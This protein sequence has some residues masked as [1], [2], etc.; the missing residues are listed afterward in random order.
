MAVTITTTPVVAVA[1][2]AANHFGMGEV[3]DLHAA[4]VPAP[5][6]T[7]AWRWDVTG[8]RDLGHF[9]F[10]GNHARAIFFAP[11]TMSVRV[12]NALDDTQATIDLQIEAPTQWS[13]GPIQNRYHRHN[14]A[15]AA[16]RAAVQIANPNHVS[17]DNLEMR[18]GNA[19]P[20]CTGRYV[21]DH[22]NL[23]A[24]HGATFG[25]HATWLNIGQMRAVV[26]LQAAAAP[27][28]I[29]LAIDRVGSHG[30]HPLLPGF[31]GPP[32]PDGSFTW[33]IPWTYRL[34]IP[35]GQRQDVNGQAV[36]IPGV[37]HR[38]V[39]AIIS[40]K[41]ILVGS[42]MTIRKGGQSYSCYAADP[43]VGNH[44]TWSA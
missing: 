42:K 26:G 33:D 40:H 11:G 13:L 43:D 5:A 1:G 3:V 37:E 9:S 6:L 36:Q 28:H 16:F 4:A 12:R 34:S 29:A 31:A 32:W 35:A 10:N 21:T 41:E 2:R 22:V 8:G 44:A 17:L 24:H 7:P 19:M 18:E 30:S 20:Q 14:F 27:G 23:N 39:G 15:H 38:K 25:L